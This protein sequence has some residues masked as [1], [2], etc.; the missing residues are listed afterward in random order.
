MKGVVPIGD[1][2]LQQDSGIKNIPMPPIVVEKR[3]LVAGDRLKTAGWANNQQTGQVVVTFRFDNVG[4]HEFGDVTK[5]NVHRRFAIVLDKKVITAPEIQGADPHRIRRDRRQFQCAK[6]QQ[7]GRA[8]A[9]RC[10][11]GAA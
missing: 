4:A 9:G 5:E 8:A 1:E 11:A 2:L 3:V 6:R 10:A 7:S